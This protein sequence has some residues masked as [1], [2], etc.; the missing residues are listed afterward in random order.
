MAT[1]PAVEINIK[2]TGPDIAAASH[3]S[4]SPNAI[5]VKKGRCIDMSLI[6]NAVRR[7]IAPRNADG[8]HV[9]PAS[10][11]YRGGF[12]GQ[13]I[14]NSRDRP[15]VVGLQQ[16]FGVGNV[17]ADLGV[18]IGCPSWL[19]L[20]VASFVDSDQDDAAA[21]VREHASVQQKLLVASV[22]AIVECALVLKMKMFLQS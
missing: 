12:E 15:S 14:L 18:W 17:Y 20:V 5:R 2:S 7:C 10:D 19:S 8:E 11:R 4:T 21:S 6:A 16:Q 9:A 13:S 22:I 1:D 3:S